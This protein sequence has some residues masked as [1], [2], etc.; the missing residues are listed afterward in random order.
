MDN[1][2]IHVG[3]FGTMDEAHPLHTSVRFRRCTG[4]IVDVD[5]YVKEAASGVNFMH[6]ELSLYLTGWVMEI[7]LAQAPG[8]QFTGTTRGELGAI[9]VVHPVPTNLVN[10]VIDCADIKAIQK[11]LSSTPWYAVLLEFPRVTS[12]DDVPDMARGPISALV[13]QHKEGDTYARMGVIAWEWIHFF[14]VDKLRVEGSS[15]EDTG[16]VYRCTVRYRYWREWKGDKLGEL[17]IKRDEGFI[18]ELQ[19]RTIRLI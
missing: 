10:L 12:R 16:E 3:Y 11:K 13:C 1:L 14:K 15:G 18:M 2:G 7:R 8:E 9:G 6:Y 5:E 19:K 4:Q 17:D